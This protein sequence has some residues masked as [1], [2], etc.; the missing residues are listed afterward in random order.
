MPAFFKE[1]WRKFLALSRRTKISMGGVL[2]V[3]LGG[4]FLVL[5][6]NTIVSSSNTFPTVTVKSIG[7]FGGGSDGVSVLGTVQSV[8]EAAILAQSGGTV[9]SVRTKLGATVPAGFVIASLDSAAA[10]AAVLQAQG[11]YDAAV[12]AEKATALTSGNSTNSLSVQQ[13]SARNTYESTYSALDSAIQNDIGVF[14][15]APGPYGPQLVISPLSS[16][17]SLPREHQGIL[18]LLDAWRGTLATDSTADPA[19]LLANAQ[20]ILTKT[21]SFLSDL[22]AVADQ[23]GSGATASQ[24]AA[25][26]AARASVSSLLA[27]VSAAQTAYNASVTSAAVGQTQSNASSGSSVT[28]SEAAVEQALGGLRSAQAA[29]E[30]TVIRAPIGGVLNYLPIHVGDN[31]TPNQH[32]ATVAQNNALE[33]VM[34]LSQSDSQRV[35]VGDTVMLMGNDSSSGLGSAPVTYKGVVTTV[36]PALDPITKQI[37]VDVAVNAGSNLVN[38]QSVQ[39][40]LPSVLAATSGLK[41]TKMVVAL[42]ATSTPNIELPLAAVKLL[43]NERDVFSVDATGHIVAHPVEIGN[44]IGNLI[45]ITT[46]LPANLEIVTDARGLSAGDTVVIASATPATH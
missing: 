21:S 13:T 7:S 5:H 32:V 46:P 25:L 19:A 14:F 40:S 16:G 41:S 1:L 11:G 39:V 20:T 28:S 8:S 38:G 29:Y 36:A 31:V 4:L 3:L 2:V 37:E 24:L 18:T 9:Q 44:V 6:G 23:N 27:S 43:S 45:Q 26:A 35:A 10:S 33:V 34:Y 42:V 17:D 12:A 22:G 30:K 15:G